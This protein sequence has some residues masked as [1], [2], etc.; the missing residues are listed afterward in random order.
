MRRAARVLFGSGASTV[1]AALVVHVL[2][3]GNPAADKATMV[4]FL[5]GAGLVLVGVAGGAT[6]REGRP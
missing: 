1:I 6:E 2:T 3:W 5:V 4:V